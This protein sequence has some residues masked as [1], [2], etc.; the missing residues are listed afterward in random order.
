M[1]NVLSIILRARYLSVLVM[2]LFIITA[3]A[4]AETEATVSVSDISFKS[5]KDLIVSLRRVP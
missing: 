5:N 3:T 1:H 2:F 4:H